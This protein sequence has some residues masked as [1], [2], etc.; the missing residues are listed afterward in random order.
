MS[1]SD[2]SLSLSDSSSSIS[3]N[4]FLDRLSN[5]SISVGLPN[6]W[7]YDCNRYTESIYSKT[8]ASKVVCD[9]CALSRPV[10][11]IGSDRPG[12]YESSEESGSVGLPVEFDTDEVDSE[13]SDGSNE[14]GGLHKNRLWTVYDGITHDISEYVDE[15]P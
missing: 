7:C 6:Q 10:S 11:E 5:R 12:T 15:H 8:N 1:P 2:V 9:E 4:S 13:Q 14:E 3:D